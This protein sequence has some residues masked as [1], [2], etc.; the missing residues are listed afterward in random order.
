MEGLDF[1]IDD[2]AIQILHHQ[3]TIVKDSAIFDERRVFSSVSD[4]LYKLYSHD[5]KIGDG[6]A[7]DFT[8]LIIRLNQEGNTVSNPFANYPLRVVPLVSIKRRLLDPTEDLKPEKIAMVYHPDHVDTPLPMMGS[9]LNTRYR[10]FQQL[11]KGETENHTWRAFNTPFHQNGGSYIPSQD[12]DVIYAWRVKEEDD[13]ILESMRVLA[14]DKGITH[15]AY[16]VFPSHRY[17]PK[18]LDPET[19]SIREHGALSVDDVLAGPCV[20]KDLSQ[21]P[22]EMEIRARMPLYNEPYAVLKDLP[23]LENT[24][25]DIRPLVEVTARARMSARTTI[26]KEK[27]KQ[28]AK[29]YHRTSSI[30]ELVR[31]DVQELIVGK[32]PPKTIQDTGKVTA[33][34]AKKQK[35]LVQEFIYRSFAE[36]HAAL[37]HVPVGQVVHIAL[38]ERL[39][40]LKKSKNEDWEL[41]D[42][43]VQDPPTFEA[44]ANEAHKHFEQVSMAHTEKENII[45]TLNQKEHEW[46]EAS[47]LYQNTLKAKGME[48]YHTKKKIKAG[49]LVGQV[50]L[51]DLLENREDDEGYDRNFTAVID[52]LTPHAAMLF[53]GVTVDAAANK[54]VQM[55]R[56]VHT[57]LGL[58]LTPAHEAYILKLAQSKPPPSRARLNKTEVVNEMRQNIIE[59]M[60][61]ISMML[62]QSLMPMVV[63]KKARGRNT[64]EAI[65]NDEQVCTYIAS[66]FVHVCKSDKGYRMLYDKRLELNGPLEQ[67]VQK[68]ELLFTRVWDEVRQT[69]VELSRHVQYAKERVN[70]LRKASEE[71]RHLSEKYAVWDSFYPQRKNKTLKTHKRASLPRLLIPPRQQYKQYSFEDNS[72][73]V[74]ETA[75]VAHDA[76]KVALVTDQHT[77]YHIQELMKHNP[78]FK[79]D[80]ALKQLMLGCDT[81]HG[82]REF[83]KHLSTPIDNDHLITLRRSILN[84]LDISHAEFYMNFIR[85]DLCQI[86]SRI[87]FGFKIKDFQDDRKGKNKKEDMVFEL[88]KIISEIANQSSLS[89]TQRAR[90]A[91]TA[92]SIIKGLD[93]VI[94]AV[95]AS[96]QS[97]VCMYLVH[98]IFMSVLEIAFTQL[99]VEAKTL[100][101]DEFMKKVDSL[102]RS[103]KDVLDDFEQDREKKK[104]M[105][106]LRMRGLDNNTRRYIKEMQARGIIRTDD[107]LTMD[108]SNPMLHAFNPTDFNTNTTRVLGGQD[109]DGYDVYDDRNS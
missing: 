9:Y 74:Q 97:A 29:R 19:A 6:F 75:R 60:F 37:P 15:D 27:K 21:L 54:L 89:E 103:R 35:G 45:Q 77:R 57:V 23:H 22:S 43:P 52:N 48:T 38:Q 26:T 72:A 87:A 94:Y 44:F 30:L 76:I 5:P 79:D 24:P 33:T 10:L 14:E 102:F 46:N 3:Q 69:H 36:A 49:A 59:H 71:R 98:Y 88:D 16:I 78:L 18:E 83:S 81:T 64:L 53:E 85:C 73:I 12:Q 8:S 70:A 42:A 11:R 47:T 20:F 50:D 55:L 67:S 51:V 17:V 93:D 61:V 34:H 96:E 82:W 68:A 92:T 63:L 84:D 62:A 106:I 107:I 65:D 80:A 1:Y 100:V 2:A 66:V 4:L 28:R 32:K 7:K 91:T 25:V 39:I 95:S 40:P 41:L 108:L 31:Q 104:Q 105:K 58:E 56:K 86:M 109:D 99:P 13:L 101:V 90:L